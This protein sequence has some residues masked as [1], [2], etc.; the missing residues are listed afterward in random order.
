M[1]DSKPTPLEEKWAEQGADAGAAPDEQA[2]EAPEA[3]SA[4]V[5][6]LEGQVADLR[7]QLLRQQAELVNF[8]RRTERDRA[9]LRASSRGDVLREL[10]PVLDD[11]ERAVGA[12]TDN[13][14]AY[15]QGVELILRTMKDSFERLGVTRIDPLGEVFDPN[16]HEA[17]DQQFT[18]EVPAGHVAVVYAP[19]YRLGDRLLRPASVG[20]AAA[21]PEH[22]VGTDA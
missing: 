8:R 12:D 1:N 5:R 6:E 7:D 18:D 9:D 16:E 4:P 21:P 2:G 22:T 15:R 17:L 19:G 11:F 3:G 20:V 10:L 13:L 14:E